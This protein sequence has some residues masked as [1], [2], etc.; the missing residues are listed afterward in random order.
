MGSLK[1]NLQIKLKE[2]E[3]KT[4]KDLAYED[5]RSISSLGRKIVLEFMGDKNE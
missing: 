5:K 3:Y 1:K 4:L 2:A